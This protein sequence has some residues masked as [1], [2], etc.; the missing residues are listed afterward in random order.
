MFPFP[1]PGTRY[2]P[3][4]GYG[5][6]SSPAEPPL[7][8]QP[9][10]GFYGRH[11]PASGSSFGGRDGEDPSAAPSGGARASSMSPCWRTLLDNFMV[12]FMASLF[13][14]LA[15]ILCWTPSTTDTL[16]FV[17]SLVLGLVLI[18]IKDED[19][20]FPDTSPTVTFVLWVLGGACA[21]V[22]D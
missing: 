2:A 16:Q 12:E 5:P 15:T 8:M 6:P 17:P 10:M 7:L 20:F 11:A 21:C 18:C 19:Y 14:C 13:V 3:L 22:C 1:Q 9:P 4:R